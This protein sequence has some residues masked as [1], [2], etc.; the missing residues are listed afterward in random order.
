MASIDEIIANS[1]VSDKVKEKF[2]LI[3]NANL[4]KVIIGCP[5]FEPPIPYFKLFNWPALF[6]NI[7]Y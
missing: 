6:F 5:V 1:S 3:N 2:L 7:I 4:K